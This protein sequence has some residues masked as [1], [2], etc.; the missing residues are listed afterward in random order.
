M[1]FKIRKISTNDAKFLFDSRNEDTSR[2]FSTN[3]RNLSFENHKNWLNNFIKNKNKIG[4]IFFNNKNIKIGYVRFDLTKSDANVSIF[5][6]KKF[7]NKGIS[8]KILE[9][10]EKKIKNKQFKAV[11]K[12][13][14]LK[15]I[16][17]FSSLNYYK[18]KSVKNFILMKKNPKKNIKQYIKI[19]DQIEKVRKK[20]NS[21]WM[22][23][24]KIA[25][26]HSPKETALIMKNI[27][28]YDNK[29]GFLSKKLTK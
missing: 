8:K 15:S 24:L 16:A 5:V 25:F 1:S 11:V 17:L 21:N 4:Y 22:D 28:N 12:K 20:N 9:L 10:A 19:I 13:N 3:N 29:I 14:N 27:Y 6:H 7:R 23:I 18:Y 26:K 2:N